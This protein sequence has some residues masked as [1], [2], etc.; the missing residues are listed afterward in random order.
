MDWRMRATFGGALGIASLV[1]CGSQIVEQLP[2]GGGA[3]GEVSGC[4]G[5]LGMCGGECVDTAVDPSHCGGCDVVCAGGEG[6]KDGACLPLD[7][8]AG[9][10]RCDGGCIDPKTDPLHCGA[11]GD[12]SGAA[13]GVACEPGF[14]CD[15]DGAC[16]LSCQAGLVVCDGVCTDPLTDEGHCGAG[17]DCA[18]EPGVECGPGELCDGSGQCA[19]S[20]QDGLLE[21]AGLCTDPLSNPAHCSECDSPCP[22]AVNAESFCDGGVCDYMCDEGYVDCNGEEADGCEAHPVDDP[23]NCGRCGEVCSSGTCL[24]GYCDKIVFVTSSLYPAD[25]GGLLAGD[26]ICQ[27][28]ADGAGLGGV[29]MAWLSTFTAT[30]ALR[31]EHHPGRYVLVDGT[32]VAQSWVD[33]IDSSLV[34]PLVTTEWSTS[35]VPDT[36]CGLPGVWTG[37]TEAGNKGSGG[38]CL[39]W[40]TTAGV[41]SV[42]YG[43]LGAIDGQWSNGCYKN[44]TGACDYLLPIYCFEQ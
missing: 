17:P 11:S 7:C 3:G 20:C 32:V 37:T 13:A 2:G 6:C 22:P 35:V 38:Q 10:V 25:F 41:Q 33:L 9:L 34:N 27:G 4:P 42:V 39:N 5:A 28:H 26:A 16:G 14:V 23:Q 21:C 36:P 44:D 1:A 43:H 40:T 19:V 30:P 24:S 31:L 8:P 15:G 18:A 12:C 29:Y